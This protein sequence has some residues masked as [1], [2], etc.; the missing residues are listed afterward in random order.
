LGLRKVG[1]TGGEP[2][3]DP[4]K[5]AA[6]A[7]FCLT[8]LHVPVHMHSNGNLVT[9]QMCKTGSLLSLFESVSVTFLGGTAEIH[10]NMTQTTGS[11][12]RSFEGARLIAEAGLPLTCYFI[13]LSH[14]CSELPQLAVDLGG[15]GVR[16][17]RVMALAPS[18]R[19]RSIYETSL[20]MPHELQVLEEGLLRVGNDLSLT[21]EAGNCTRLSMPGFSV[22]D[23]HDKCMSGLNRVHINS[24]GHV[25]P[26]TAASGVPELM[27]GDLGKSNL[28][29]IWNNNHLLNS[30]RSMHDG[31]LES[32]KDC[33][34]DKKCSAGCMVREHSALPT[35]VSTACTIVGSYHHA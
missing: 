24:R 2:L 26:C 13:P 33:K 31:S 27:I 3:I 19:A 10:D 9:E 14:N 1:L 34:K 32:C 35:T 15:I 4:D 12:L 16:R 28:T 6:I 17:I 8:E 20:P 21:I 7:R 22:L 30:I 11:F 5:L 18:G 25:F 29:S 23:G